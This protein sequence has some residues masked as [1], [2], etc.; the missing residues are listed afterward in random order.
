ME[1]SDKT[2]LITGAAGFIGA[3]LVCELFKMETSIRIIG[4]DEIGI[5]NNITL[6]I[7]SQLSVNM[8]SIS[9]DSHDGVF[10][11]NIM[12]FV[13]DTSHLIDLIDKLEKVKG[14][15]KVERFDS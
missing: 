6:I 10:E 9:F 15:T 8:R 14:V 12:V 7:S 1:L 11:G 4:I 13:N 5:V 2:I 3:N